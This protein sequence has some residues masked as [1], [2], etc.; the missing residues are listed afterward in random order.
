[1][2]KDVRSPPGQSS[3]RQTTLA[4]PCEATGVGL[5]TGAP[6][7]VRLVPAAPGGGVRFIRTD[8]P[9]AKRVIP[10]RAEHV[11]TTRLGTNLE[12]ADG[13][14]VATVEHLLAAC[15]GVGLDN[16]DVEIDGPETPILD[17]CSA[18]YL[19]MIETAGL[20]EQD[21][22]PRRLRVLRKVEATDGAKR[23]ALHPGEGY[24]LDVTIEFGSAVIGRQSAAFTWAP[25]AFGRE[26]AWART[27]GFASEIEQLQAMGLARGGSLANAILVDGDRVLNPGGLAAPDEFARHKL[28]DVIGDLALAGARIEGRYEGVQPGHAMNISLLRTLFAEA[29]AWEWSTSTA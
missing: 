11:T 24:S 19:A 15:I 7:R 9:A 2:A 13:A 1:M 14:S 17:G 22:R 27:F 28:L 8:F 4:A 6:V 23:V 26:I 18:A 16:V 12:N 20:V 3:A 5:H 21:A 10:A 29:D 25:G